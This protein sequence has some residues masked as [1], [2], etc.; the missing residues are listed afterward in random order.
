MLLRQRDVPA[1]FFPIGKR[2]RCDTASRACH[3]VVVWRPAG[4]ARLQLIWHP[5]QES[6]S[7]DLAAPRAAGPLTM[8]S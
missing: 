1:S 2:F 4:E 7:C 6:R 3:L 8:P 5:R